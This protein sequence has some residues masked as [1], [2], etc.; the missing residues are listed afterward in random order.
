[1]FAAFVAAMVVLTLTVAAVPAQAQTLIV[2]DNFGQADSGNEPSAPQGIDAIAQ[3]RDGNL[4]STSTFGG[5]NG[6]GNV[7]NITPSGAVSVLFLFDFGSAGLEPQSG[8]TLGTD[9]NFYGATELGGANEGAVFQVTPAGAVTVLHG[10]LCG[11][12]GCAPIAPPIQGTDGNFYG[13]TSNRAVNS[14]VYKVTTAGVLTTLHT[15][16]GAD[17]QNVTAPL[18]QGA[19]GNYYGTADQGGTDNVGVIFKMTQAGVVTVLHNLVGTDGANASV[20]LIQASDGNFY[21]TTALGGAS[22]AGVIFKITPGGTY[23]VLHN[24]NGTTDGNG[25]SSS[26]MQA[27]DGKLYGVTNTGGTLNDGTIYSITTTGTFSVLY[28]FDL[29]TGANPQSALTQHTNGILY[30]DTSLG[31]NPTPCFGNA[32]GCGVFYSLNVGLGP[33]AR[34]VSTSG[35]EG[36]KIGILGQGFSS[37]SVVKFGGTQATSFTRQGTTFITATV[38]AA[39]L[40][41]SVTVKTGATTLTSSKTFKVTP[42]FPSFSPTSGSLGTPL[43]LTGT[44]LTQTTKVTFGNVTATTVTVNSDTQVT[45]NVP[46]GAVT[47]KIVITT[48]GGSAK[49]AT[50]FTVN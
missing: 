18:V 4:Y 3:G 1:M 12:D 21:G 15:F 22:N 44:G 36:A 31:G 29:T 48:K 41:G 33:F 40:T 25:P 14:T 34:L 17:G 10:F 26:L 20:G 49:S 35:K 28:N 7:F 16:T 11:S 38:P 24:L 42:T 39:A 2:L 5:N 9:G 27:T 23:S 13:T 30:G 43:V 6:L 32:T 47:G 50:N 8:L 46:T 45:A 37:S 19:D